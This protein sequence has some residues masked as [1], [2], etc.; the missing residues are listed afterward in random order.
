MPVS[1]MAIFAVLFS[2]GAFAW[3]FSA[4]PRLMDMTHRV[5][6]FCQSIVAR[7]VEL[8]SLLGTIYVWAGIILLF[9]GILYGVFRGVTG[10]LRAKRN[11]SRLPL[12]R[13]YGSIILI[14]D[15]NAKMAFTHGLFNPKIYISRGLM[16]GL[17]KKEL[18]AVFLHELYH[19][20]RM[21][22]LKFFIL[23][24]LQGAFFYIPI[25][26]YIAE[27]IITG[28][29]HAADRAAAAGTDLL[30][31]AG[32]IIKVVSLNQSERAVPAFS[33]NFEG[34]SLTE[35]VLAMVEDRKPSFK[36]PESGLIA[37]SLSAAILAAGSLVF[38]LYAGIAAAPECYGIHCT[39]HI[40]VLGDD[41]KVHCAEGQ[42]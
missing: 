37:I 42:R 29:E 25:S 38:P 28:R 40:E 19:L 12:S 9:S 21:H 35:R 17:D 16:E 11:I 27:R 41:C 13:A 6:S 26:S 2:T 8:M 4:L 30:T 14:K 39:D 34:G 7:C 1:S 20:R 31:V 23:Y 36:R 15:S 18:R 10:L 32:A 22:S 24:V 5:L 3:A 33:G